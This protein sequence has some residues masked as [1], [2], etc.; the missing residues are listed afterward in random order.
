MRALFRMG[1]VAAA[2]LAFAAIVAPA[3]AASPRPQMPPAPKWITAPDGRRLERAA[4]GGIHRPK[5]LRVT[6]AAVTGNVQWVIL[7]C[8]YQGTWPQSPF[9][10][11]TSTYLDTMFSDISPGLADYWHKASYGAIT[12]AHSV[13]G[14]NR[15]GAPCRSRTALTGM[16]TA[17][18]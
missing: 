4:H 1:V 6:P 9:V 10:Q 7:R 3:S 17:M 15:S 5:L 16:S 18:A 14:P 12:V 11:S 13:P 2:A 8:A